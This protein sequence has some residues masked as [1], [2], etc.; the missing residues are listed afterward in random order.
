MNADNFFLDEKAYHAYLN[1]QAAV[2]DYNSGV[3]AA[4]KEGIDEGIDKGIETVAVKMLRRGKSVEEIHEDT[5][6]S[7]KRIQELSKET[8]VKQSTTPTE[9]SRSS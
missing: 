3:N 4:R 7:F 2:W 9:K 1:R 5:G 8:S 6:L